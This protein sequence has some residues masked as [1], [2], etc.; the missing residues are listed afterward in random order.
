MRE[1]LQGFI[2]P[3]Y[4]TQS[5]SAGSQRLVNCYVEVGESAGEPDRVVYY[6]A[7]GRT[8]FATLPDAPYRAGCFQDN[9]LTAV[10]GGTYVEVFSDGTASIVGSVALDGQPGTI[11]SNGAL[12]GHQRFIVA[13]GRGYIHD[14]NANTLAQVTVAGFPANAVMG[15]FFDQYFL[16]LANGAFQISSLSDGTAWNGSDKAQRTGHADTLISFLVRPPHLFLFGTQSTEVWY[17]SGAASFPFAPVT[18]TQINQ[19]IGAIWS[20]AV[21]DS[22]VLW[23]ATN[24]NGDR[25]VLRADQFQPTRVS[26]HAVERALRGCADVS[27]FRGYAYQEEGHLFYILNSVANAMTWAYDISVP[28]E[29]AWSERASWNTTTG[30]FGA[31]RALGHVLAWNG[32]HIV[33]DATGTLYTQAL[34]IYDDAGQV[35]RS[36]RRS[37]HLKQDLNRVFVSQLQLDLEVGQGLGS[38]QGSQPQVMLRISRDGGQTW[39]SELWQNVGPIGAYTQRAIWNRLGSGRNLVFEIAMTDP[40]KRAWIDAEIDVTVGTS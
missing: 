27:D 15:E 4:T 36:L 32:R 37:P 29:Y 5:V 12:A 22:S 33:G 19:G 21:C 8:R 25:T 23:L 14:L 10:V 13:G 26:T 3:T 34:G 28:A 20:A 18:G 6:G 17:N 40:V 9:R 1:R 11:S 7:P 39:G 31:D 16:V 30:Q 2:G 24:A 38:G 35:L